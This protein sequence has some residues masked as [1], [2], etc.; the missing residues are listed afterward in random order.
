[1]AYEI[2]RYSNRK[3][4]DP[5]TSRYVTLDELADMI[6]A[7]KEIVVVDVATKA[8]LTSVTLAQILL[9]GVKQQQ[10]ALP[11]QFL[12]Q[13]IQYGAAWQDFALS[14]LKTNLEGILS[15]Q[16]EADRVL[17][18]WA[19]QCGWMRPPQP[20]RDPQPQTTDEI[21]ALKQELTTLQQQLQSLSDRIERQQ[22]PS[23]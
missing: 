21:A 10:M 11:I 20:P 2:K 6:R 4:Y 19:M 23:P 15:S 5:Q 14:S 16:R 12:H 13:L 9:E 7:G 17:R 3:L 22:Q 18:Q 8:D 1:M